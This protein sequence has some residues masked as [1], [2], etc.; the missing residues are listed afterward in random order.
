MYS[1]VQLTLYPLPF[2]WLQQWRLIPYLA[3]V[4]ALDYFSKSIFGNFVEFQIGMMMK[5]NSDRQVKGG[6]GPRKGE[7][8]T[9]E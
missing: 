5:D 8:E 7:R 9:K 1:I 2:V 6:G 3:A 4:Y